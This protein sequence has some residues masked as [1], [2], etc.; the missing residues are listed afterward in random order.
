MKESYKTQSSEPDLL[1]ALLFLYQRESTSYF[2]P[3]LLVDQLAMSE[4][5]ATEI[6]NILRQ[7][8]LLHQQS[9]ELND[10]T[11]D[12]YNFT[13]KPSP[14]ALLLFAQECVAPPTCFCFYHGART[15]PYLS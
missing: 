13:L 8:A 11:Q 5:R 7:Y 14:V 12:I 9:I 3:R 1:E 15:K 10:R 2:T 6:I 4:E